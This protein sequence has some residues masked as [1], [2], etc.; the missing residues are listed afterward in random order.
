M[1]EWQKRNG[2]KTA[3]PENNSKKRQMI[4]SF[5][6]LNQTNAILQAAL[7]GSTA[8]HE[9]IT[10]NIANVDTPGY[11]RIDVTF[12]KQLQKAVEGRKS[13]GVDKWKDSSSDRRGVLP[14]FAIQV[15]ADSH[16]PMRA[17]GSNVGIDREMV[18]LAKNTAQITALTE[19]LK[20]NYTKLETAIRGR[21][22]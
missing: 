2:I 10:N 17:D 11:Q 16:L 9:A 12:E 20:R 22:V 7:K 6:R 19:M 15:S 14:G 5:F 4:R 18:D 21:N 8:R 3:P 1:K 13:V